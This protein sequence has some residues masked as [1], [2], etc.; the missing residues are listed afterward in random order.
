MKVYSIRV[1]VYA[2]S[3]ASFLSRSLLKANSFILVQGLFSLIGLNR[4]KMVP[5]TNRVKF[6]VYSLS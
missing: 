1:K 3:Q 4:F 5:S 2:L 6:E